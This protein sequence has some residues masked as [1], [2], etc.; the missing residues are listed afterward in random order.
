MNKTLSTQNQRLL[1]VKGIIEDV[2]ENQHFAF[3]FITSFKNLP[4]YEENRWNSN[5]FITYV[6]LPKGSDYKKF[7]EK[8]T[9]LDRYLGSYAGLPFKPKFFLQPLESIHLHSKINFELGANNEM[10]N[11]WLFASVA[12]IIL[13]L[14]S[15]TRGELRRLRL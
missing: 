14:A 2:P 10:R 13:L 6:V 12:F 1:T 7:E 9:A 11:I 4:F 15:I 3:D 8:L 5:N